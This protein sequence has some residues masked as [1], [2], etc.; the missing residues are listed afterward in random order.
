MT[1]SGRVSDYRA[2]LEELMLRITGVSEAMLMNFFVWRLK[3]DIRREL[4]LSKLVDLGDSMA[5]VQLFED[6]NEDLVG[7]N[8]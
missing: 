4:L 8:E 5:K 2:E 7:R 3:M 6:R 1:Q